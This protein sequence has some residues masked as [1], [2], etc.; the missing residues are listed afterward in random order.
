M[1]ATSSFENKIQKL[2]FKL[3]RMNFTFTFQKWSYAFLCRD[4]WKW[5]FRVDE[6][7]DYGEF[8]ESN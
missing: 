3:N 7:K 4:Y 5:H 2:G 6:L 1:L 8:S